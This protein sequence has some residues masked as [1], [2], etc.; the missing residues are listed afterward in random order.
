MEKL[1]TSPFFSVVIP[2][3][4]H[5][6]FLRIALKSVLEQ[7]FE[8]FEVIV[9]DNFSS[10][11]TKDVVLSFK[12]DRIRFFQINN[13]GIIASSRNLGIAKAAGEWIAFLDSDDKWYPTR[14]STIV[15]HLQNSPHCDVVS[16]N[17]VVVNYY[18]KEKRLLRYGPNS[19]NLYKDMLLYGNRLSTSATVISQKFLDENQLQFSERQDL[20][21]VEDYDL[22]LR[23]AL[24]N[25]KFEFI[26]K[27]E[28]EFSVHNDNNSSQELHKLNLRRL[29]KSHIVNIQ[30][31]S[32]NGVGLWRDV[33]ACFRL[34]DA[35]HFL[36]SFKFRQ[37]FL[38]FSEF[39]IR[40]L[41][42][43]IVYFFC[44][45]RQKIHRSWGRV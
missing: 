44:R 4:N 21:T 43:S 39:N 41:P 17:E 28:G 26:D 1:Q 40:S 6:D 20:V 3:Y 9:V 32:P 36:K 31:F 2:T 33:L 37:A 27:I 25:A 10:D 42:F 30:D 14:L 38:E 22:W 7:T 16:T 23:L 29:I 19:R 15:S 35:L 13:F 11:H 12:D 8:N 34:V 18:S 45:M 24:I 5:A